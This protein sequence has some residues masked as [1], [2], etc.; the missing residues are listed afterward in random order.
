MGHKPQTKVSKGASTPAQWRVIRFWEKNGKE[1]GVLDITVATN[2]PRGRVREFVWLLRKAG[3][4]KQV[5]DLGKLGGPRYRLARDLG[6]KTPVQRYT[7]IYDP[8]SGAFIPYAARADIK[9]QQ[10]IKTIKE[11]A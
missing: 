2:L 7:G 10:T 8:N 1:F 5:A 3:I 4:L 9:Q 11:E 6:P